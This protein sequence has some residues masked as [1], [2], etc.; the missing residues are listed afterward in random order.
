MPNKERTHSDTFPTL[1]VR[2]KLCSPSAGSTTRNG[3]QGENDV[4]GYNYLTKRCFF[5][6][7]HKLKALDAR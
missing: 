3:V 1:H 2:D 4:D 6:K 5:G 7:Q